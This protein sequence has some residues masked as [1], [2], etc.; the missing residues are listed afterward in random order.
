MGMRNKV[1][2]LAP[3]LVAASTLP[4]RAQT[5]AEIAR[6]KAIAEQECAGCHAMDG[7]Q[8]GSVRG[9]PAPAFRAIAGRPRTAERLKDLVTTPPHPMPAIPLGASDVNAIVAYI[10]SLK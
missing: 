1:I 3:T 2:V 5:D 7:Q 4:A 10:R 9:T 6:G 8:G